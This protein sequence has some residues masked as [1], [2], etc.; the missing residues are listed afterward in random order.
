VL[1][2]VK[3]NW[4]FSFPPVSMPC[5]KPGI[6]E[7]SAATGGQGLKCRTGSC[8][9]SS[10][11][12]LNGLVQSLAQLINAREEKGTNDREKRRHAVEET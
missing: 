3:K 6:G 5:K 12:L 7:P 11:S 1:V 2:S 8:V 9:V 10:G 4:T